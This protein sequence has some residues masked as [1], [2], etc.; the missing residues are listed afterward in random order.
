MSYKTILLEGTYE[1]EEK[2]SIFIGYTKRVNDEESAKEFIEKIKRM[3]NGA[4]HNVYGYIIGKDMLLQRYTDDGEPQGTA[5]IP[6]IGVIKNNDLKDI[7]VVVTRYFG[8]TLLGVGGLTRA[9]VNAASGAIKNSIIVDKVL[10]NDLK[11]KV[12]YDLI[13]KLQYFFKEKNINIQNID[14]EEKVIFNIRC[15]S[16][17]I[18]SIR[19][20][21]VDITANN[22]DIDV[23]DEQMYFKNEHKYY[24]ENEI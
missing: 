15:E 5:G 16:N 18:E 19:S 9:Y 8:G 1:F 14:Y 2:K 13:G 4:R 7:V 21:V 6:I 12:N 24:L 3:N 17:Q 10:G 20:N 23:S 11:I 22:F